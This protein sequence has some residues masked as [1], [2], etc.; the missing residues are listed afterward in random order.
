MARKVRQEERSQLDFNAAHAFR[1]RN[2]SSGNPVAEI[3]VDSVQ[4]A[5]N[6]WEQLWKNTM[7]KNENA[8]IRARR[9]ASRST[10]ARR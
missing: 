4:V 2:T 5:L 10:M 6:E 9:N 7:R 8:L 3:E 1:W